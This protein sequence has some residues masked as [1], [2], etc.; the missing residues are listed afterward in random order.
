LQAADVRKTAFLRLQNYADCMTS[1]SE[2]AEPVK[3]GIIK[4]SWSSFYWETMANRIRY[5]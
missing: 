5:K 2:L 3:Y 1:P 4:D